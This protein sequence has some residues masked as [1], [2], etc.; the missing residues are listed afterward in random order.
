MLKLPPQLGAQYEEF[1]EDE[2]HPVP[3]SQLQLY[4]DA[5]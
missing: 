3:Q 5:W 4:D 2:E 1:G